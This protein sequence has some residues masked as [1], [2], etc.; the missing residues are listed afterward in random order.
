[1]HNLW[2]NCRDGSRSAARWG[3][4]GKLFGQIQRAL[5]T[6]L[7]SLTVCLM[8][9]MPVHAEILYTNSDTGYQVHI[10]D[11]AELL[12]QEE[13][14]SLAQQMQ[15]ITAYGNAMFKTIDTNSASTDSYARSYYRECFGAESGTMFL[16][17]MDNRNIWIRN[18]GR[19]SRII[20]NAYSD[21]ITDNCYRYASR[22]D[23]YGCALEA[24]SQIEALLNGQRI[25]QPMKYICNAFLAVIFSLLITL[26]LARLMSRSTAPCH[27]DLLRAA[28]HE[29]WLNNP[30]VIYTHT[31]K[32]Y[33]P[34]SSDSGGG[35]SS[36]GGG[37]GGGGSSGSGGGHS[38]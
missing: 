24:F 16:I 25:A 2:I 9:G 12:S 35:S 17:D 8:A 1:M 13:I 32:V 26:G 29:F 33:D 27:N 3:E 10:E 18:D 22:G 34:P 36:G 23:Y 11:D 30:Q 14:E 4:A 5:L 19:I 15:G 28:P 20:T 21:T 38:F 7:A 37:G 31:T 6:L